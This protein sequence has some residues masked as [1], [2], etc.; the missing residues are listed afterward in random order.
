MVVMIVLVSLFFFFSIEAIGWAIKR[1]HQDAS[2]EAVKAFPE[3]HFPRGLFVDRHHSWA[4]LTESGELRLGADEFLTGAL[5]G[6]DRIELP[7]AG[8]EISK[9]QPLATVWRAGRKVEIPSPVN[10][11]VV[12]VNDSIDH[13]PSILAEDPYKSGWIAT[14]WPVE[15]SEALKELKLGESAVAWLEQEVQRLT[16]FLARQTSPQLVGATLPDGARPVIGAAMA[17]PEEGWEK[18]QKEFFS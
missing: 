5:G 4:R 15:H 17:L 18:F 16:E 8:S 13:H 7:E 11:T 1:K 12:S 14:V 2:V 3:V 9:G 6:I 10:G